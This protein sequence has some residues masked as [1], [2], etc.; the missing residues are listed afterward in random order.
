MKL[1]LSMICSILIVIYIRTLINLI[2]NDTPINTIKILCLFIFLVSTYTI[3]RFASDF[4]L[5][6]TTL[7]LL[8]GLIVA[9]SFYIARNWGI[10]SSRHF[11]TAK[12]YST[13]Q[14]T[15]KNLNLFFEVNKG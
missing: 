8:S 5:T 1:C 2:C 4:L 12:T 10:P 7:L 15:M 11:D 9:I 13:N 6:I 14:A 3:N